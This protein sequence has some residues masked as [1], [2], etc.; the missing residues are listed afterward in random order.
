[1]PTGG[2]KSLTYQ[3]PSLI[4]PG[5]TVVVSPLLALL[6]D[7]YLKMQQLGVPAVRLDSTVGAA[8]RRAALKRIREGGPR[9]GPPTPPTL[10]RHE[11]GA[12]LEKNAPSLVAVDE[13]HCVSE[14]GHDFR[15]A[16]L[17]LG[18]RL[19]SLKAERILA[20]T[21]TATEAVRD[22]IIRY[23]GL[24]DPEIIIASPHRQN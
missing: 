17:A 13:A 7:Q 6:E 4:L 21:A 22:D 2:G 12:L 18:Q 14:W 3:L 8:D 19:Q 23:L 15:P 20:L 10:A 16:Y 11:L 24:R 9:L 5:P 1:M